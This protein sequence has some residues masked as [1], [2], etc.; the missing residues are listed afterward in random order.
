[1]IS[2]NPGV[3]QVPAVVDQSANR[4]GIQ[5]GDPVRKP[6]GVKVTFTWMGRPGGPSTQV[7]THPQTASMG[8]GIRAK[9][10]A[11]LC[12][13]DETNHFPLRH[14]S[15]AHSFHDPTRKDVWLK[16]EK[17]KEEEEK[18]TEKR[19]GI[20]GGFVGAS[21]RG[22]DESMGASSC[23]PGTAVVA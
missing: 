14:S 17:E 16:R 7:L 13:H 9:L 20:R 12:K 2:T 1:M 8:P 11:V 10:E 22:R 4:S 18:K 23:L 21:M 6:D 3:V 5:S 15:L 19:K